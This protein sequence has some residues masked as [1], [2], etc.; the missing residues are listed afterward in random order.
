MFNFAKEMSFYEKASGNKSTRDKSF[1]RLL[2][3]PAIMAGSLSKKPSAK[4]KETKTRLLFSNH[5]DL[6]H[7]LKPLL[8][9]NKLGTALT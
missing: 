3:S 6:C 8:Q 4:P 2:Q 1:T 7:R 9:K 5:N